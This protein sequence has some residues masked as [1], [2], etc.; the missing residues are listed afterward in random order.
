MLEQRRSLPV[1]PFRT[2]G[3]ILQPLNERH[4]HRPV[5]E[6]IFA[7]HFFAAAPA[8]IARQVGLRTPQHQDLAVVLLGLRDEPR[9]VAF[10]RAR[11][12]DQFRVPG[13]AHTRRLR[14]L[15]RGDRVAAGSGLAL[16]DSVN[17][18]GT[19][20][21]WHAQTGHSGS[22]TQAIDLLVGGHQRKK[23]VD[24]LLHGKARITEGISRLLS[25][26]R[27]EPER[28]YAESD[29]ERRFHRERLPVEARRDAFPEVLPGGGPRL[30][31]RL[32]PDRPL[33]KGAR[34]HS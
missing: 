30:T 20:E 23:I 28:D 34:K 32:F 18:F 29:C 25:K 19:A 2:F 3:A 8:R 15:S 27:S 4:H 6:R 24:A 33:Q 17:A 7:V 14:K 11:L 13:F 22:R 31:R 16:N 26:D 12:T 5:E 10:D 21:V 1:F 9:L